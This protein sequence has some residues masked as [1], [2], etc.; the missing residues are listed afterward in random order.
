MNFFDN[1]R[2]DE[3][4]GPPSRRIFATHEDE[5][6]SSSTKFGMFGTKSA[7]TRDELRTT[8]TLTSVAISALPDTATLIDD[9]PGAGEGEMIDVSNEVD[10]MS[11]QHWKKRSL[12]EQSKNKENTTMIATSS[13][14]IESTKLAEP[15]ESI[16]P[17]EISPDNKSKNESS[18]VTILKKSK[19][20][21]ISGTRRVNFAPAIVT[22]NNTGSNV[23]FDV[24]K[25]AQSVQEGYQNRLVSTTGN[26]S[27]TG[28]NACDHEMESSASL[29]VAASDQESNNAFSVQDSHANSRTSDIREKES[30]DTHLLSVKE[31][32]SSVVE[33]R[34]MDKFMDLE[35]K[36]TAI[37]ER[38]KDFKNRLLKLRDNFVSRRR[39]SCLEMRMILNADP[40]HLLLR[41]FNVMKSQKMLE[42]SLTARKTALGMN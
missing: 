26:K 4:A 42:A 19:S 3:D 9:F 30:N 39:A 23:N 38:L 18:P 37:D 17:L 10:G 21:K 27:T 31:S 1:A 34:L 15:T 5:D 24:N 41:Y 14:S 33:F 6:S 35:K 22:K 29:S 8:A 11:T 16:Q 20:S 32:S 2:D 36:I 25:D 7:T 13:T 40:L 12:E 28:R